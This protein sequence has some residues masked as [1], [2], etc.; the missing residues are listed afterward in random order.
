MNEDGVEW[1]SGETE[2][3]Q[4]TACDRDTGGAAP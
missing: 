3:L 2:S 1:C 4:K